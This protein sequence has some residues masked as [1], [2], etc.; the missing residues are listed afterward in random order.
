MTKFLRYPNLVERGI[1]RNRMTLARWIKRH[2]F[3]K[4]VKL[5]PQTSAWIAD[6][7]DSWLNARAAARETA[8]RVAGAAE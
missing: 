2:G 4:P 7:V 3:P 6:E 8:A 5:G 1:V